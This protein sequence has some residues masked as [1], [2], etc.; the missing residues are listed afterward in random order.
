MAYMCTIKELTP[1]ENKDR[2]VLATFEENNWSVIVQKELHSIGQK[3]VYVETESI[4]PLWPEFQFLEKRCFSAKRKGYVIK[5]MAMGGVDSEG[6][7]FNL[8]S[9]PN[10]L[11]ANKSDQ[12]LVDMDWTAALQIRRKEDIVP[13]WQPEKK[14]WL[15][16]KISWLMWKLFRIKQQRIGNVPSDFPS[17][18]MKT[19]ETQ[20]QSIPQVFEIMKNRQVAITLKLDGQSLTF[21]HHKGVFTISTRNRSVYRNKIKKAISALNMKTSEK[22]F[23]KN[24]HLYIA[25]FYEIPRKLKDGLAIQGEFCGPGIQK[26]RLG[27]KHFE[28]Y[29]FNLFNISKR[30]FYSTQKLKLFCDESNIKM[31]PFIE[32]KKFE[33]NS[34]KEIEQYAAPFTYESGL[35]AEGL[36]IR[37][38]QEG[39]EWM[40][41]PYT[42]M[43]GSLS[44][45]IISPRYKT[46]FQDEDE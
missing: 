28:F 33:W 10:N 30:K 44:M 14:G 41:D 46:K 39:A 17:Y 40:E 43:H 13:Q 4:L 11:W 19:D 16:N 20:M 37:G 1:I 21:A 34:I 12:A 25:A 31:V 5:R 15:E 29:A 8:S 18:L 9:L 6:I 27:L 36:V 42:K 2:I 22:F 45:K 23:E 35:P 26:N 7:V 24:P 32:V 38:W 3:V